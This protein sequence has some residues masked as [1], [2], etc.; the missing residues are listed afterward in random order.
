M[1]TDTIRDA[2]ARAISGP[3]ANE[4]SRALA[5]TAIAAHLAALEAEG[6][7]V[8]PMEPTREMYQ[9]ALDELVP[10][11]DAGAAWRAMIAAIKA[12]A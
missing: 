9:A 10:A 4:L 1:T 11:A 2:V 6:L 5:D 7:V 3:G 12:G 8:V